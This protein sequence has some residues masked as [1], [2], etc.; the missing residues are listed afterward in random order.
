MKEH[1]EACPYC[2]SNNV[3]LEEIREDNG[4][5]G[6]GYNSWIIYSYYTCKDCKITFRNSLGITKEI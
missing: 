5:L 1:K 2:K 6:P 4:V 3:E